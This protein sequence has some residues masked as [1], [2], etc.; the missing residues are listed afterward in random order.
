MDIESGNLDVL[1]TKNGS[2]H[3]FFIKL[4]SCKGSL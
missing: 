1:L 2:S 3:T 4:F